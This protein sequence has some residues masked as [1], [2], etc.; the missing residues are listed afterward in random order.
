MRAYLP[1]FAVHHDVSC[2]SAEA[3]VVLARKAMRA[4]R[5]MEWGGL[6]RRCPANVKRQWAEMSFFVREV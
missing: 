5:C 4:R 3:N 1:E 2:G 6:A